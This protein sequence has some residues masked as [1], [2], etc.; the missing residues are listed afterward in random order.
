M[1]ELLET[2]NKVVQEKGFIFEAD[3]QA[4]EVLLHN[5]KDGLRFSICT[6]NRLPNDLGFLFKDSAGVAKLVASFLNETSKIESEIDVESETNKLLASVEQLKV[7]LRT[8]IFD[9][10]QHSEPPVLRDTIVGM[11]TSLAIE[12]STQHDNSKED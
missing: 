1:Q 8:V 2:L 4:K 6:I 12:F 11:L 3:P 7:L 10:V 5:K 9:F